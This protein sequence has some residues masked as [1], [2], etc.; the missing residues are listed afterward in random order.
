M[1]KVVVYLFLA[2]GLAYFLLYPFVRHRINRKKLFK[3]FIVA[4]V[5]AAFFTT[6]STYLLKPERPEAFTEGVRLVRNEKGIIDQIGVYKSVKF[7][8]EEFPGEADN[9]A[10]LKFQLEGSK[11]TMLIESRV[12]KNEE[13]QWYIVEIKKAILV[14]KY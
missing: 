10:D 4:Y 3:W 9:P 13:G 7:R 11:G 2:A 14:E 8:K 12:A 5:L 1:L 6:L